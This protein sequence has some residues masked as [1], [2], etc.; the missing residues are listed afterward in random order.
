MNIQYLDK[1]LSQRSL[2]VIAILVS[3]CYIP[4]VLAGPGHNN[5]EKP[6]QNDRI[7]LQN[8]ITDEH[9]NALV[10]TDRQQQMAGI[11]VMSLSSSTFNLDDVATATLIVDRD[12]TVTLAPQLDVRVLKRHVV[13]GQL[14]NKNQVLLTLGGAAVAQAQADYITAA[15]EWNRVKQ[16]S[17]NTVSESRRLVAKVQAELTRANLEALSMTAL[18]I[19]QLITKPESIGRYQLLAPINGRVQQDVAL[20][21]QVSAGGS[22][23]MQ[24]TDESHLWVEAQL[25]A[26]QAAGINNGDKALV[27][28]NEIS[29]EGTIIGRS[30]ELDLVTRTEQVLVSIDNSEYGLHAGQFAELY[31]PNSLDGGVVLPDS[32]L[33][34][35]SDGHWQVFIQEDDGFEAV[36]VEVIESQRGMNMVKGI[37][38]RVH[39][40][41]SGAFLLASELA[42]AGFDIHNH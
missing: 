31:L 35:S 25:S 17:K 1:K 6:Q 42:K 16:M 22:P 30:H 7:T 41:I 37:E 5:A 32:A 28:V 20:I 2:T 24:L 4:Q 23:L 27:R 19:N 13:P 21:G 3:I 18:Q 26:H 38:P 11:K 14:V 29:I 39:V 8:E 10:L 15:A 12:H 33:T 9:S 40:V 34:R 36:E